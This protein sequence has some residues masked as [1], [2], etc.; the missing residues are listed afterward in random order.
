M[1]GIKLSKGTST[2]TYTSD[3]LQTVTLADL[4]QA[5]GYEAVGGVFLD[6]EAMSMI[7]KHIPEYRSAGYNSLTSKTNFCGIPVTCSNKPFLDA[8]EA[9][10]ETGRTHYA[11]EKNKT[12]TLSEQTMKDFIGKLTLEFKQNVFQ[13][14]MQY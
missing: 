4:E 9:F 6:G 10:Q 3:P 8:Y 13:G 1:Q 5:I 7:E 14:A 2:H 11:I 12:Y